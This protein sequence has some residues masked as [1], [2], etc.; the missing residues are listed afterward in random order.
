MDQLKTDPSLV[1]LTGPTLRRL[2]QEWCVAH[3]SMGVERIPTPKQP[4]DPD[5]VRSLVAQGPGL[6]AL[7]RLRALARESDK[8]RLVMATHETRAALVEAAF[9]AA[10][11]ELE[12]EAMAVL[13]LVGL[14]EAEAAEVVGREE[15]VAR[16]DKVLGG[17]AGVPLEARVNAG[18]AAEA[19]ASASGAE[20]RAVLGAAE[21]IMDGLVAL[22][23]EKANAR[24]VRVGIRALFALCLAKENRPRA[25]AAGAASALARR[26]AEGGAGEPE[27]AL[28]AVERLC[29]A[30]GGR[31][32]VVAG[33]GGGA[34]AVAALVLAMSGRAAERSLLVLVIE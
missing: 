18:A 8:N 3:R 19:A 20:A 14:G 4:A 5:L 2:I 32:A 33:A 9:G 21:G 6:P 12:A 10:S 28:A 22:V 17:G 13:G 34:A 29:R 30:E 27:R 31:E 26:V 24:A 16:L 15:R 1:W 23:E 25:V 7:R 11:E